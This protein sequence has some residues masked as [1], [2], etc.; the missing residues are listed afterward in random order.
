M[1]TI[2]SRHLAKGLLGQPGHRDRRATKV[3]RVIL[4]HRVSRDLEDIV[5]EMETLGKTGHQAQPEIP[6]RRASR[7]SRG[8]W[9]EKANRDRQGHRVNEGRRASKESRGRWEEKA[10]RDRQD[11][12]VSEDLEDILGEMEIQEK[13]GRQAQLETQGLGDRRVNGGLVGRPEPQGHGDLVERLEPQG[14]R[15]RKDRRGHGVLRGHADPG[16]IRVRA[17]AVVT[18]AVIVKTLLGETAVG[19]RFTSGTLRGALLRSPLT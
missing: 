13:T 3:I 19:G 12:R 8:R 15:D 7:E 11:H 14:H 10:N 18:S 2:R 16:A 5:D 1:G 4:G 6:G 9:E 17:V